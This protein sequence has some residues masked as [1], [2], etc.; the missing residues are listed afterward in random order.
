MAFFP[1]GKKAP[2]L[3]ADEAARVVHTIR[4]AE[5]KTSGEIRIFI[6]SRCRFVNPVDRAAEVFWSLKMD[7]TEERNGVLV[8]VAYK[9]HQT[10]IWA[11]QGIHARVG[12]DFWNTE[13]SRL[14]K[15][16]AT[17]DYVTGL[18]HVIHDIGEVM[19][20]KFPYLPTTDKNELPDDI[21][22]GH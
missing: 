6:E 7:H 21:V 2:F 17:D 20:E 19:Q 9:D 13:M 18:E 22:F 14:L 12:N 10:A 3:S 8:Y 1:F 4:E 11:D 5:K 15:H 16:F